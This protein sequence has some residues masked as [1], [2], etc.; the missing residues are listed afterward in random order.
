MVCAGTAATRW[1][2]RGWSLNTNPVGEVYRVLWLIFEPM[3]FT[4][5]GYHLK[6][7]FRSPCLIIVSYI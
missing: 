3:L 2:R 5:S 4:L 7:K 6:V 1:S